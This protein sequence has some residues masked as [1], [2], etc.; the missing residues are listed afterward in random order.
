[1]PRE[2]IYRYYDRYVGQVG[3][4][5]ATDIIQLSYDF[6]VSYSAMLLRLR[7]LGIISQVEYEELKKFQPGK[8]AAEAG[9]PFREFQHGSLPDKYILMATKLY[10]QEKISIGKLAEYMKMSIDEIRDFVAKLKELRSV[11]E[12]S[13]IA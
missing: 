8:L 10:F 5:I 6:G 1:M 13:R 2:S 7:H 9:L 3:E 12:L 4:V 11:E